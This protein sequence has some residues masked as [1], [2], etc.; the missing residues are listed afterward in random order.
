MTRP[1]DTPVTDGGGVDR[2]SAER[3]N[4][5]SAAADTENVHTE[6]IT[7]SGHE[8]VTGTHE[9]TVEV[10]TDDYLTPAGD[11]I[12]AIDA[13]RAPVDFDP[14]FVAACQDAA[15]TI[16]ATITVEGDDPA[17]PFE[18]TVTGRGHPE[19]TFESDRGAV[20]RT[21]EYVD[22]RTIMVDADAA[23]A[24]LDRAM[25]DA[26]AGGADLE[27]TLTVESPE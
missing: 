9:T 22:E 12:L 1:V 4:A 27:L 5:A 26:L 16:T 6:R 18:A 20:A 15:A 13:N 19:L 14:A 8:H 10:T 21:S 2:R 23:A 25:I 7:A 17:A 24:D 3:E 11:C